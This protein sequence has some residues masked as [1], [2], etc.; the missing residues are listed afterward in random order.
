MQYVVNDPDKMIDID[1][2]LGIRT[3]LNLTTTKYESIITALPKNDMIP[4]RTGG[5]SGIID[6]P[7]TT[8]RQT[9][10]LKTPMKV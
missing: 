2:A 3:A 7:I 4:S 5:I 1:I 8:I 10:Y 9:T 6:V